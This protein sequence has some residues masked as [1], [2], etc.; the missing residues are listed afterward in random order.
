[1]PHLRSFGLGLLSFAFLSLAAAPSAHG[2]PASSPA[3]YRVS[4]QQAIA[5]AS[6]CTA[7]ATA[8]QAARVGDDLQVQPGGYAVHLGWLRSTLTTARGA[9][10]QT[11]ARLMGEAI[12]R[13]EQEQRF[14]DQR[15]NPDAQAD[16]QT[17][18]QPRRLAD[19]ILNRREFRG[20]DRAPSWWQLLEAR[21]WAWLERVLTGAAQ[22]SAARP[23]IGVAVEWL[24]LTGALS[25]LLVYAFK[26]LRA[27]HGPLRSGWQTRSDG[28]IAFDQDWATIAR[29]AAADRQWREAVHAL[30]WAAIRS[31]ADAG[32]WRTAAPRTPREYLRL[33]APASPQ[34]ESL[35]RL[36]RLLERT[37][38][39]RLEAGE[40]D[41][42]QALS[43]C[44]QLSTAG[45][46]TRAGRQ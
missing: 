46:A 5:L 26:A 37:W 41:Y 2:A 32:H 1:M 8:C 18:A 6:S 45:A 13:L 22:A 42:A 34:R 25:G 16:L 14:L 3:A 33:L 23:W 36:T 12:S 20:V 11:R 29:A 10:P 17:V 39:A 15:A 7:D 44:N 21:F 30:Y 4:L 24:L 38:Y 43:L 40:P 31:L 35:A 28:G 9:S 19:R 27:E